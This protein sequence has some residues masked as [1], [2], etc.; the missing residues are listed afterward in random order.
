MGTRRTTGMT[1]PGPDRTTASRAAAIA[2]QLQYECSILLEL[3]RERESFTEVL[4]DDG[5]L[6]S[7]SPPS[8]Q[9]DPKDKL[10]R[11]HSALLQCHVLLERAIAREEEELGTGKKAEYETQRKKVNDRL[12][13]ILMTTEDLLKAVDGSSVQTPSGQGSE[14][15][16]P[17]TL[18]ELK[19]WV[20]RILQEI[21]YWTKMAVTT[22][23]ELSPLIAK[24][25]ARTTRVKGL[26]SAQ[27]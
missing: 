2:E 27:R 6:V 17:T 15:N 21:E 14:L 19:L 8:S 5:H 3:Y 9:S 23:R 26:R 18:F 13:L 24:D 12:S 7:I 4:V 11:V 22:F 25:Q 1:A 16:G 20:Y 10:W